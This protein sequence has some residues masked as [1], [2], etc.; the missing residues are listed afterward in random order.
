MRP[1]IDSKNDSL[2]FE[3]NCGGYHYLEVWYEHFNDKIIFGNGLWLNYV[4]RPVGFW[5]LLKWWWKEDRLYN[6]DIILSHS[7]IVALRDKLNKYLDESE[8]YEREHP[9]TPQAS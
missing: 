9:E 6:G 5:M 1:N 7:D 8:K 4:N 3:C 2:L